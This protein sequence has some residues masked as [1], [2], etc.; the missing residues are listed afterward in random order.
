[1]N[2]KKQSV[3]EKMNKIL[4]ALW[5]VVMLVSRGAILFTRI[6]SVNEKYGFYEAAIVAPN[7]KI[8]ILTTGIAHAYCENLFRLFGFTGNRIEMVPVYQTIIQIVALILLFAGCYLLFGKIAAFASGLVLV[9]SPFLIQSIYLV[10]PENF[11]LLYWS[12]AFLLLAYLCKKTIKDGWYRSN[13][14][15]LYLTILGFFV[16][17]VSVWN[18]FGFVLLAFTGYGFYK[19][20]PYQQERRKTQQDILQMEKLVGNEEKLSANKEIMP[21]HSQA[22]ILLIG[23]LLGF[24]CTLMKY[25]GITGESVSKQFA[26]WKTLW[27]MP[28]NGRWQDLHLSF[29]IWI[30]LALAFGI[31]L[32]LSINWRMKQNEEFAEE[33]QEEETEGAK[34]VEELQEEEAKELQEKIEKV[35]ESNE[36]V[37]KVEFIE[38]PL[39]LP[40]KHE[41]RVMDFKVEKHSDDFDHDI[42]SNDD[43]DF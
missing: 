35:D 33:L 11:Y 8:T 10:S 20:W 25:T 7:K 5:L 41:K 26:W 2:K 17:L 18:G 3:N 36:E 34:E 15:E 9:G 37:K 13:F 22:F 12:F 23:I 39:P 38:N 29:G 42:A 31:V 27:Q 43:F 6:F 4:I 30:L 14:G 24:F 32:Q 40:K 28:E 16:G 19:M 1:M 21:V